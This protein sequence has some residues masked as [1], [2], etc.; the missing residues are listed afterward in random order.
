MVGAQKIRILTETWIV[1][2]ILLKVWKGGLHWELG[3]S[4]AH[5]MIAKNLDAFWPC[6]DTLW[7]AKPK[8][9]GL[10]G[11]DNFKQEIPKLQC[12]YYW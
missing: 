11:G 4:S 9:D 2:A 8:S 5:Y 6:P 1:K 12:G 10:S 7:E 3:R